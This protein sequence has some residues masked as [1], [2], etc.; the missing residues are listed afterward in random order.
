MTKPKRKQSK[1]R[2]FWVVV[3]QGGKGNLEVV[4]ACRADF[5]SKRHAI[6]HSKWAD[7]TWPD[8]APHKVTKVR[9][10]KK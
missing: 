10:V 6:Q 9:E 2:E 3:N 5:D 8:L 4:D 1:P 7:K